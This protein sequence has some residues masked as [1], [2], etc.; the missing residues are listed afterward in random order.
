LTFF[1]H[2]ISEA[3]SASVFRYEERNI[4]IK[5]KLNS[6]NACYHSVQNFLSSR[7]LSKNIKIRIYETTILPVVVHGCETWSLTLREVHR[8]RM[9]ENWVLRRIFGPRRDEVT[10]GW[11]KL[12][13]EDFCNLYSS[14]SIIRLIKPTRIRW[15]KY[16]ARMESRGMH[17][18]YWWGSQKKRDHWEDEDVGGWRV[19]KLIL[20]R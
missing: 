11:R 17:I 10:K 12:H 13:Y 7:L 18:G 2:R 9:F 3:G 20:D 4:P 6:G 14:S 1:K 8:L 19:L 15:A 5:R 16:T